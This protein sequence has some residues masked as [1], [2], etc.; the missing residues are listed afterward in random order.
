VSQKEHPALRRAY[1]WGLT[2]GEVAEVSSRGVTVAADVSP[3]DQAIRLAPGSEVFVVTVD[4][5][6][7][8]VSSADAAG[9]N[10]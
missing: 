3:G 9:V 1:E 6:V 10:L 8:L 5:L 4:E 2:R 7:E